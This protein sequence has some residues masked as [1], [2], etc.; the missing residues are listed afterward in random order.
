MKNKKW[1]I[2]VIIIVSILLLGVAGVYFSG[3]QITVAR[4]II[5]DNNRVYMVYDDRPVGLAYGKDTDYQTGDKLLIIHKSAFAESYPEST[6]AYLMIK[7]A[8]G[9]KD[10]VPQ[11]ALGVLIETG[12]LTE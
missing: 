1:F 7:I 2:P 10:D 8:S 4:C 11:K 3:N 9:S 12:N 6:R 5:S